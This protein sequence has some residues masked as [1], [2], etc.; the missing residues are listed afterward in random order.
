MSSNELLPAKNETSKL[1]SPFIID[2]IEFTTVLHSSQMDNK[3]YINLKNN[4]IKTYSNKCYENYGY[5]KKIYK[6]VEMSDGIIEPEDTKC[7]AKYVLKTLCR[8]CI[9]QKKTEIICKVEKMNN[10]MI[11]AYFGPIK[12]TIQNNNINPKKFFI[13]TNNYIRYIEN[14]TQSNIIIKPD[15]YLKVYIV[16]SQFS[17]N[18]TTIICIGIIMDM[19]TNDEIQWFENEN[20]DINGLNEIYYAE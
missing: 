6:I 4:L 20:S 3:L 13:D 19:A 14:D 16:T 5:V 15:C 2:T 12:F 7:N 18:D 1:K 11:G 17:K 10:Q 9:P 8:L